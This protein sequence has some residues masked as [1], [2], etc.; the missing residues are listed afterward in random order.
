MKINILLAAALSSVGSVLGGVYHVDVRNNIEQ[1]TSKF[2]EVT[3][4]AEY[5]HYSAKI[6]KLK[7][8]PSEYYDDDDYELLNLISLT[9]A[10]SISA[11]D[12][13][14][15]ATT[16]SLS[17]SPIF[18][19]LNG[20]YYSTIT[21]G[22]PPQIF[23]VALDTGSSNLW[24]P[25][26]TCNS[27]ACFHHNRYDK[28]RSTTYVKNG[29]DFAIRYIS[30]SMEGI[31][32]Q[33]VVNIAGVAIPNQGFAESIV[34]PGPSLTV[35]LYD[36]ILG[37]GFEAAA[38]G[39]VPPHVNAFNQGLLT[40]SKFAF[41]FNDIYKDGLLSEGSF[42]F[43]GYDETKYTGDLVEIPVQ[44][45]PYIN[46]Y[47][48]WQVE[49]QGVSVP[50]L[51]LDYTNEPLAAAIDTGSAGL[52]L[53]QEISIPLHEKLGFTLITEP[54]PVNV[55]NCTLISGLPDIS[56]KLGGKELTISPKSYTFNILD[57]VCI[58]AIIGVPN[59]AG[60]KIAVLGDA[61]LRNYYSIYDWE[62]KTISLGQRS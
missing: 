47:I 22:T 28:D 13:S 37:L 26:K 34:E 42:S 18:D 19:F 36:G 48:Y 24:V 46:E 14:T 50:G 25:G 43:G 20:Y 12:S 7:Y 8:T 53:P 21:V 1:T 3:D 5:L 10:E 31:I 16:A 32:D 49:L 52:V 35:I 11:S 30:G 61:F 62:K 56:F 59:V 45:A 4:W 6:T 57:Q 41:A 58:S 60:L 54:Y 38:L 51:N 33:D 17:T 40:E 44:K 23:T 2:T 27:S 39:V 29:T 55:I 15:S 9:E